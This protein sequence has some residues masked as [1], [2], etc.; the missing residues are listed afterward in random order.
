MKTSAWLDLY[1]RKIG[2]PVNEYMCMPLG[3]LE[4]LVDLYRASEGLIQIGKAYNSGQYI[5]DLL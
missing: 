5:P 3:Q 1:A 4:D 2:I